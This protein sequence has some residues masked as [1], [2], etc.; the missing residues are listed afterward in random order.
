[1]QID[2]IILYPR[3]NLINSMTDLKKGWS[4]DRWKIQKFGFLKVRFFAIS[5]SPLSTCLFSILISPHFTIYW[6][7]DLRKNARS[8]N[9]I[10]HEPLPLSTKI[11]TRTTVERT[12]LRLLSRIEFFFVFLCLL[13]F[14]VQLIYKKEKWKW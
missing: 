8:C 9:N 6:S 5:S 2:S 13:Y 7:C 14:S 3:I 10:N 1:M 4:N 12:Y 11:P